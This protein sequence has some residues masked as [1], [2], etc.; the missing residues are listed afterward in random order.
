MIGDDFLPLASSIATSG[1]PM[2]LYII[3]TVVILSA[4]I[5]F[6]ITL[7]KWFLKLFNKK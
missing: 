1:I 2:I 4:I 5:A 3:I 7:V 6:M